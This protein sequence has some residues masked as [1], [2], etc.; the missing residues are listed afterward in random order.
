MLIDIHTHPL[1]HGEYSFDF[2][3]LEQYVKAALARGCRELGFTDHDIYLD[4][5][6]PE[7]IQQLRAKYPEVKLRMG[8]EVDYRQGQDILHLNHYEFDYLIGSVHEVKGWPFD[9]PDYAA[10]YDNWVG[11]DLYRAYFDLVAQAAR[12]RQFQVIGHLDVIRVFNFKSQSPLLELALPALEEIR[13]VGVAIEINTNGRY[14]PVGEYYPARQLLEKAYEFKIP[15]TLGSDAHEPE[16]VGRDLALA[17]EL[18]KEIGYKS[19]VSFSN[20]Q[21]VEYAL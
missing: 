21:S 17:V 20:K 14:K 2:A 10:G 9:H 6:R 12:S 11:D 18:L 16:Y 15:V 5:L 3:R 1:A 8:L 7:I 19:V 13:D 4:K